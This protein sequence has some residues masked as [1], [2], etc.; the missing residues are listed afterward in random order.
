MSEMV[1]AS[2]RVKVP[3]SWE[4]EVRIC[5]RI[6]GYADVPW[7]QPI[8]G[9]EEYIER[10]DRLPRFEWFETSWHVDQPEGWEALELTW[11]GELNY[12]W[13]GDSD[14]GTFLEWLREHGIPFVAWSAGVTGDF[15][16]NTEY[17]NGSSGIDAIDTEAGAAMTPRVWESL[18]DASAKTGEFTDVN[19]WLVAAVDGWFKARS[20][21]MTDWSIDHLPTDPPTDEEE[22]DA[23]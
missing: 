17:F 20:G 3:L 12:G 22:D 23:A 1:G 2:L 13:E 10:T 14:G 18:L 16:P 8:Y 4:G 11:S 9:G 7:P 19:R 15:P 5:R 21:D 6:S